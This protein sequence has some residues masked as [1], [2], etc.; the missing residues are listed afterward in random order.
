MLAPVALLLALAAPAAPGP[1]SRGLVEATA[2]GEVLFL[3]R[4]HLQPFDGWVYSRAPK[5]C[6]EVEKFILDVPRWTTSFD[7]IKSAKATRNGDKVDYQLELTI[8]F[9]PPIFGTITRV[10]PGVLR[11]NDPVT[12][13]YSQYHLEDVGD[14]SCLFRYR[15]VEEA[16]KSSSWVA[17]LKGL[18]KTSG[19]AGNFAAGVSSSRGFGKP[20]RAPRVVPG[21]AAGEVLGEL[22]GRGTVISIDRSQPRA[23]YTLRRRVTSKFS[24]VAWNLRNRK[25]YPEKTAVIRDASDKGRSASYTIGGFGGRVNFTTAVTDV[26]D[27]S[28]ALTITETASG[29]DISA[30]EGG[31]R[32]RVTPVDGGVDVELRFACDIVAGSAVMSTIAR[33]DPIARESFMLHV[34]LSLMGDLVGGKSLPMP[35]RVAASA[36]VSPD[37]PERSG[38]PATE[39]PLEHA[40]NGAAAR[41]DAAP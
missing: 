33:T 8:A 18:E 7:N 27:D 3:P 1:S 14:G 16:G 41:V 34:G 28:G 23:V 36:P 39:R 31:W 12:K 10:S 35:V 20:E 6:A 13:A 38:V 30:A 15:L 37:A 2:R 32:W 24:D 29:G 19:D 17:I 21:A 26:V 5:S 25:G 22:A 40:S 11:F 4:H 9:S